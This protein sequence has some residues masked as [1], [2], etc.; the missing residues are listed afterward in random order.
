MKKEI[1]ILV[2][3]MLN[4]LIIS[5]Q[6]E[7][8]ISKFIIPDIAG[9]ARYMS[10]GGAMGAVGGDA[11][12]IKDNPAGLGIYRSSEMTGTLNILRLRQNTDATWYGLNSANNYINWEQITFH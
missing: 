5:A 10:M 4:S 9:T 3:V 8:D 6:S 12:A 2:V 11:S 1:G 7:L